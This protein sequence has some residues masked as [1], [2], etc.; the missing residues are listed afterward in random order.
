M[1]RGKTG[2]WQQ[3]N[4]GPE[5]EGHDY[6]DSGR[7]LMG[8]LGKDNPVLGGALHPCPH[9]GHECS[10]GPHPVVKALQ[11]TEGTFHRFSTSSRISSVVPVSPKRGKMRVRLLWCASGFMSVMAS[12]ASVTWKPHSCADRA[13]DST[14]TLVATP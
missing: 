11:R 1:I 3:Q 13:V 9:I 10:A 4:L 2:K 6:T 14:P 5:P 7:V 12:T 8:Q